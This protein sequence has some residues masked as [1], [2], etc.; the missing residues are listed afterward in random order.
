MHKR[1]PVRND[2]KYAK[3][4]MDFSKDNRVIFEQQYYIIKTS[5]I[6]DLINLL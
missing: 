3:T 4:T 2:I 6:E 5:N 1:F